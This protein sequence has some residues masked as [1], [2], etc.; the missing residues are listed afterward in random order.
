MTKMVQG[1]FQAS[2]TEFQDFLNSSALLPDQMEPGNPLAGT[3]SSTVWWKPGSLSGASGVSCEWLD[4]DS[5]ASCIIA[6]GDDAGSHTVYFMVIYEH[7]GS[8]GATPTV[9]AD[10][11][12][13][14]LA[15]ELPDSES[16]EPATALDSRP[17]GEEERASEQTTLPR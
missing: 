5:V 8:T 11:N 2:D 7:R 9:R 12:W 1:R 16:H 17:E 10:P 6:A 4:G 15:K 13:R 14:P 3:S